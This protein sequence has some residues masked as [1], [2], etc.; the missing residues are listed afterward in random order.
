[1]PM[2]PTPSKRAV[3]V[4]DP[5]SAQ[6]IAA[7]KSAPG[8][9]VQE[10]KGLSEDALV[11]LVREID[12]WI[13]RGAT[14]VTRRLIGEAPQLR[15]VARAGAGLDN[16]DVVAAKERGIAV[17]NVPGA[18][19]VA[20]AELVFGLLLGLL[21]KIP[22]ADASLRRGEWEKSRFQGRELRGKT[23]GI[24]GLGKIGRAVA[25]RAQAFEMTCVGHDPLVPEAE[26]RSLGVEPLALDALL[27]RADIV[28]LHA[29]MLAET[30][31]LFGAA[32]FARMPK[33]AILVNA[34]R[35]G[36]V[37]EA[38]LIAALRSGQLGGAALDV[39]GEEPPR[40]WTLVNLPNV[41]ATPH[42]GAATV[43]AQEAVGEEIVKLLLAAMAR[44]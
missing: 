12:A 44:S 14:K 15:W 30:K 38:A 27:A 8:I 11:P 21:R 25:K 33:G 42:V 39:F 40:D 10:V 19:A 28:T 16:I 2:Q 20:V 9:S 18:N 37:D 7:L 36:L 23:L 22:A 26:A 13:V 43:E 24:V 5:L 34:A 35:G 1:M 31:G 6:A 29:P 17:L 41:V 4:S 32:Q 3:L